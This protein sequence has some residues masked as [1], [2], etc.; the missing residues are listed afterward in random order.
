VPALQP[1]A[2]AVTC[3]IVCTSLISLAGLEWVLDRR[4]LA[5]APDA[6][7]DLRFDAGEPAPPAAPPRQ[8]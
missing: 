1:A 6:L 7:L 2:L 8:S 4:A 5:P 3:L